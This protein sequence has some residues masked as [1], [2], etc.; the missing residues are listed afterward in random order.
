MAGDTNYSWMF[1]AASSLFGVFSDL[2]ASKEMKLL[3][4]QQI[5]IA[6]ENALLERRELDEQIRRQKLKDTSVR[7]EALARTAASGKRVEGSAQDYLDFIETEQQTQLAWTET[8]GASRIRLNKQAA[9]NQARA[10]KIRARAKRDESI[11]GLFESASYLERGG[12]FKSD[13]AVP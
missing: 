3:S 11:M 10:L 13:K 8:A 12:F 1:A 6:E 9:I 4:Q 2:D 5:L 7:G